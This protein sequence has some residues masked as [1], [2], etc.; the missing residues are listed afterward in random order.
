MEHV[1]RVKASDDYR[2][3]LVLAEPRFG[4]GQVLWHAMGFVAGEPHND[5]VGTNRAVV[6][7][8]CLSAVAAQGVEL[9]FD[10]DASSGVAE[11]RE[12][13]DQERNARTHE[14]GVRYTET[15]REQA[16]VDFE[17]GWNGCE[18]ALAASPIPVE[19]ETDTHLRDLIA[20]ALD[21]DQDGYRL[22]PDLE[23]EMRAVVCPV[24]PEEAEDGA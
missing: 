2:T 11:E 19:A 23:K 15:R 1:E 18:K 3:V 22:A 10:P 4:D 7:D 24:E 5:I 8:D 20:R 21:D 17:A 14:Y 12:P 16:E 9:S 6:L 13:L